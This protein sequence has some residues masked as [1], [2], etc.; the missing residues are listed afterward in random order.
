MAMSTEN[1]KRGLTGISHGNASGLDSGIPPPIWGPGYANGHGAVLAQGAARCDSSD[2]LMTHG[3]VANNAD[4]V[5]FTML[6]RRETDRPFHPF[7]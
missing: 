7:R 2:R 3:G 6:W 5:E 4:E 1:D